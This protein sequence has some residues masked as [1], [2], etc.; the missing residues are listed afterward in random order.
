MTSYYFLTNILN[1]AG[2]FGESFPFGEA[3]GDFNVFI[4]FDGSSFRFLNRRIIFFRRSESFFYVC[5]FNYMYRWLNWRV[6]PLLQINENGILSFDRSFRNTFIQEFG[7]F[8]NFA[9]LIAPLWTN[10]DLTRFGGSIFFRQTQN[11]TILE[12]AGNLTQ[13]QFC[14]EDFVPTNVIIVTWFEVGHNFLSRNGSDVS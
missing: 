1:P 7:S 5:M 11:P 9:P 4:P 14:V 3:T 12:R 8:F 13:Q 6:Y 10:L 2:Q